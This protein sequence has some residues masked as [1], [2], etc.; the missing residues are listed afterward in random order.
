MA[1]NQLN[2]S[3]TFTQW[4][5]ATQS[6]IQVANTLTDDGGATFTANTK[7]EVSGTGSILNV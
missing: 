7:L 6:L 5:T 3:N 1:I 4:L 2:T